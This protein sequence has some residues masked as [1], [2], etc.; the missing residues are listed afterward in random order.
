VTA[1]VRRLLLLPAL[2]LLAGAGLLAPAGAGAAAAPRPEGLETLL[3]DDAQLL[4]RP[5]EQVRASIAQLRELGV[6]RVRVTANWS[7]LTRDADAEARPAFDATDPAAYEQGRWQNLDEVVRTASEQG[8]RVMID[9]AFWAPRWAS[10]DRPGQRGR[11]N[12]DT[13]AY[14]EFATALARRYSGSFVVPVDTEPVAPSEDERLLDELLGGSGGDPEPTPPAPG[15]APLPRVDVYTLWNEPNHTGFLRPQWVK[16]GRR[17]RSRSAEIYRDM[18]Q[19]TYPAIKAA[20]PEARVLIGGTSMS[21]AYQD[22]G[23]GGTPP[24]RFLRELACVGPRFHPLRTEACRDYQGLPGDGWSHHPYS[25]HGTPDWRSYETRPDD[26]PLA[27]TPK[28]ARTLDRLADGGR[29]APALRDI[30]ITEYGYETNPPSKISAF[31]V[32]DQARFLAWSEYVAWR[33]PS[34]RT[35]AQFLLR[36]LPPGP[37]RVGASRRRPYGEWYSGLEFPDGRP[38]PALEMFRA[39]LFVRRAKHGRLV[40]WARL[41]LGPGPRRVAVEVRRRGASA[42][43]PLATRAPSGTGFVREVLVDGRGVIDRR[44]RAPR[45]RGGRRARYRLRYDDG[46]GHVLVSPEVAATPRESE[47][48]RRRRD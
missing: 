31:G 2:A 48:T 24:L 16:E 6:D 19:R 36:D 5:V 37:E 15:S 18:V 47:A 26:L 10:A 4:H 28:L 13:G 43:E 9:I 17:Y 35:F 21:G 20:S 30:W 33:V 8:L 44:A 41:R 27:K 7:V 14:A 32:E 38:K 40:V 45:G 29:I 23:K 34:V 11:T 12:I 25:L 1:A 22:R 3:Q 39:G 42:W 46:S